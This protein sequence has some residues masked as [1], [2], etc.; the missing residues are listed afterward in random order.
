MRHT[1]AIIGLP[2]L[3]SVGVY[4]TRASWY[5]WADILVDFGRELY[6]P[7]RISLGDVL[8]RDMVVDHY[9]PFSPYLNAF[10]FK[11]FGVSYGTLAIFHLCI[12][13]VM[14]YCFYRFF[15]KRTDEITALAVSLSFLCVSAFKSPNYNFIAPYSY[16]LPHGIILSFATICALG[17]F[18]REGRALWCFLVG[19]LTGIVCLTKVEVFF[20]LIVTEITAVLA[21]WYMNRFSLKKSAYLGILFIIGFLL[22][23]FGFT[24]Y[25]S[26]TFPLPQALK[27]ILTQY[28]QLFHNE[29]TSNTFYRWTTG[30]DRAG[31][32]SAMIFAM[33]GIY[34][35][36]GCSI[37][38]AGYL[39]TRL[40]RYLRKW[41][42]AG[43]IALAAVV[44]GLLGGYVPWYWVH[45]RIPIAFP[46][47]TIFMI[48]YWGVVVWKNRTDTGRFVTYLPMLLF[49]VFALVLLSKIILHVH[50]VLYGFALAMPAM[51]IVVTGFMYVLPDRLASRF[52]HKAVF[53]CLSAVLVG[54]FLVLHVNAT[55]LN[56]LQFTF[57]V[58]G[59]KDRI[60]TPDPRISLEGLVFEDVLRKID[61]LVGKDETFLVIP[62]GIMFNYQARRKNPV[63]YTSFLLGDLA[64][65]DESS[66]VRA[67]EKNPPD[68]VVLVDRTVRE[69]GYTKFGVD[70]GVLIARWV[71][72]N[73]NPVAS[74]G[75]LPFSGQRNLGAVIIA[76]R[77]KPERGAWSL[78]P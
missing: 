62:E 5:R 13:A 2:L 53:Q 47:I 10:L 23:L 57:F 11:V 26:G 59:G 45:T 25:F 40:P 7:W 32:Y 63:P 39:V 38:Y 72:G 24:I 49:A 8:Y 70:T 51:L 78:W 30:V 42:L 77:G 28:R 68:Y 54:S 58:G 52:G 74:V 12:V 9:G 3:L 55:V 75:P 67:I 29:V 37:G 15:L 21:I 4:L 22:P 71:K 18:A 34:L 69:W 6:I 76:K 33:S 60:M 1:A 17:R 14:C 48:L 50:L 46:L 19:I 16:A 61:G 36:A 43:L 65:H 35:L 64:M 20:A 44:V 27:Y 66:M 31:F 41:L 56:Y 73:Y